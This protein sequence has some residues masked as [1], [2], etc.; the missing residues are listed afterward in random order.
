MSV[1]LD[2]KD[3]SILNIYLFIFCLTITVILEAWLTGQVSTLPIFL[4]GCTIGFSLFW[5]IEFAAQRVALTGRTNQ[6]KNLSRMIFLGRYTVLGGLLYFLF[7]FLFTSVG[8]MLGLLTCFTICISFFVGNWFNDKSSNAKSVANIKMFDVAS[9][10]LN[11]VLAFCIGYFG[12]R[13]IGRNLDNVESGE[14]YGLVLGIVVAI[15]ESFRMGKKRRL[16]E[17]QVQEN[18]EDNTLLRMENE[19]PVS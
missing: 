10:G 3:R 17:Q 19:P 15:I 14:N 6:T 16:V 13:W 18:K 12:G 2:F 8:I 11:I 1:V 7:N 4:V 5:V 9:Y